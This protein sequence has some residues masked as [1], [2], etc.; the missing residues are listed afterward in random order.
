MIKFFIWVLLFNVVVMPICLFLA[1]FF[2]E[3]YLD[4]VLVIYKITYAF[5]IGML[6]MDITIILIKKKGFIKWKD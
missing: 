3:E 1:D 5:M 4:I 6:F 2:L